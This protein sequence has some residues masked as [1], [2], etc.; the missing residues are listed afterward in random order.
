MW[1]WV[2]EIRGMKKGDEKG[3]EG[4]G[5]AASELLAMYGPPSAPLATSN[6]LFLARLYQITINIA[7]LTCN[8]RRRLYTYSRLHRRIAKYL[9]NTLRLESQTYFPILLF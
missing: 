2:G 7:V 6:F 4:G 5:A 1:V 9:R 3:E 8:S